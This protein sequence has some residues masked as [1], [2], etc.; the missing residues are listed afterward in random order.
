MP[1]SRWPSRGAEPADSHECPK[2]GVEVL[3]DRG[4]QAFNAGDF[5]RAVQEFD[6]VVR[7]A[8]ENATAYLFRAICFE[9]MGSIA[10][11]TRDIE[12]AVTLQS[13]SAALRLQGRG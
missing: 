13:D 7:A 4:V 12:R 5:Q 10:S 8:P 1:R 11:A 6:C 3:L 2:E 9:M